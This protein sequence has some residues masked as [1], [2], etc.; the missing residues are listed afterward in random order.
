[1]D[2]KPDTDRI[3]RRGLLLGVGGLGVA[4]ALGA[5]L[6]SDLSGAGAAVRAQGTPG[7][8]PPTGD[9]ATP[10]AGTPVPAAWTPPP[11]P[12]PLPTVGGV[13]PTV[14]GAAPP[15]PPSQVE[16][17]AA[18]GATPLAGD[19]AHVESPG[20]PAQPVATPGTTVAG[21]PTPAVTITLIPDFRFDPAEVTIKAGQAVRWVNAGRSP[22][23]VTGDPAR[24]KDT[25]H[26][27]LPSGAQPWDSG[28]LNAGDEYV[29]V[30]DIPGDYVYFSIPQE[31][32]GMIGRVVV[33]G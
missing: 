13:A 31:Q 20:G 22:Q 7:A 29:H 9:Q 12:Q 14:V 11:I 5:R 10:G 4:A 32:A 19:Q 3:D 33:Q 25:S 26:V 8:G 23:T 15:A 21:T 2:T 30:F 16:N 24:A 1:M 27:A 18:P 17:P 28:V 6:A